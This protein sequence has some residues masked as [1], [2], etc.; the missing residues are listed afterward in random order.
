MAPGAAGGV[1]GAG[2]IGAGALAAECRS[3]PG[4]PGADRRRFGDLAA[5][6][7]VSS[8]PRH[9]AGHC[10]VRPP[11]G[12]R[13]TESNE[14]FCQTQRAVATS[15][16]MA[17]RTCGGRV[18]QASRIGARSESLGG[19][20]PDFAAPAECG[21]PN[22]LSPLG[23]A[24]SSSNP[25][26]VNCLSQIDSRSPA[27]SKHE[28]AGP[29]PPGWSNSWSPAR[30]QPPVPGWGG[31]PAGAASSDVSAFTSAADSL[32]FGSSWT[33]SFNCCTAASLLPRTK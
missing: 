10:G 29:N 12:G 27:A 11:H 4:A 32:S 5:P 9:G 26:G 2:R 18:G 21:F 15:A 16:R 1:G 28:R 30:A 3:V 14:R 25:V 19:T 23:F 31:L 7:G 8:S 13:P 22:S 20:A 33:T 17:A 6:T 24:A